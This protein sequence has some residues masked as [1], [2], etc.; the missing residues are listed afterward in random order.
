MNKVFLVLPVIAIYIL[1]SSCN[2]G[3][4]VRTKP[5]T[6]EELR[7]ELE[8]QERDNPLNYMIVNNGDLSPN[9]VKVRDNWFRD[10]DYETQGYHLN[11]TIKNTASIAVFKDVVLKVSYYS[12]TRS[13]IDAEEITIYEYFKPNTETP[14]SKLL[15]PPDEMS[16]FDV[17]IIS[18]KPG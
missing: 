6:P 4:E 12:Q 3:V 2:S 5:K 11:C 7:A 17:A 8:Q 1:A 9:R 10:D 16:A 13:L 14:F 15:S 18:A